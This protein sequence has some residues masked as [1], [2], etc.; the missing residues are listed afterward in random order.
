MDSFCS[1]LMRWEVVSTSILVSTCCSAGESL[2]CV[3]S[4]EEHNQLR[5]RTHRKDNVT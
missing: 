1:E 3:L 2:L 4:S 5:V